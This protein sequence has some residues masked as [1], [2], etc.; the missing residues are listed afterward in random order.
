ME[1]P[2]GT[3]DEFSIFGDLG[4]N[5]LG[6]LH[7]LLKA[8]NTNEYFESCDAVETLLSF[9]R[10]QFPKYR[11]TAFLCLAYLVDEENDDLILATEGI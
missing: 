8:E 6:V 2:E 3:A 9:Y 10:S 5:V 4:F 7:N 11:M 1:D